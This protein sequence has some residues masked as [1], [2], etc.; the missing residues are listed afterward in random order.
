MRALAV[1]MTHGMAGSAALIV[2]SVGAAQSLLT[3]LAF[4]VLF[5]IGSIAGMAILSVAIA[6]PLRLSA[7]RLDGL[8]NGLSAVI[9][10]SSCA[11][12]LVMVYQHGLAR[13]LGLD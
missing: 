8:F 10:G 11:L 4:I 1:G 6:I 9:G 13:A 5:G 12:G 2:L 3:G 7:T